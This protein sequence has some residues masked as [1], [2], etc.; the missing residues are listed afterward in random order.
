MTYN[1]IATDFRNHIWTAST[2][3]LFRNGDG[4]LAATPLN[5]PVCQALNEQYI[6]KCSGYLVTYEN[7]SFILNKF[8]I[9]TFCKNNI[10][11]DNVNNYPNDEILSV[12]YNNGFQIVDF[13]RYTFGNEI[14]FEQNDT[15]CVA[16]FKVKNDNKTGTLY[17]LTLP[18]DPLIKKVKNAC[19]LENSK[20]VK[21]HK[22]K[23]TIN[24]TRPDIIGGEISIGTWVAFSR[25]NTMRVGKVVRFTEKMMIIEDKFGNKYSPEYSTST[26]IVNE[27][28]LIIWKLSS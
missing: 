11:K 4:F 23:I 16:L 26:S 13:I 9:R 14:K 17:L 21:V 15:K 7:P 6:C 28:Q 2:D 19:K 24:I 1:I 27:N 22:Q 5:C 25:N 10:T 20:I 8:T 3:T 18:N 12:L